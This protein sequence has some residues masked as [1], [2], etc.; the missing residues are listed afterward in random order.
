MT[1]E[2]ISIAFGAVISGL[3]KVIPALDT[4]FYTKLSSN[5]RGLVMLGFSL[6][7]PFAMLGLSCLGVLSTVSCTTDVVP[8]LLRSWL[9]FVG[10]NIGIFVM[11]PE[12]N[13]S[14]LAK[15]QKLA[16][17]IV[18]AKAYTAEQIDTN[19]ASRVNE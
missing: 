7:I 8:G 16:K 2:E 13:A 5:W 17:A 15:E 3:F 10:G 18:I 1:P 19:E 14:K 6:L 4:W 12:S 11:T 9:Y